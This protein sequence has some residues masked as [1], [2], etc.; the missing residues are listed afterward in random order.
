MIFITTVFIGSY[1]HSGD[2]LPISK[3]DLTEAAHLTYKIIPALYNSCVKRN[4]AKELVIP[5]K[6]NSITCTTQQATPRAVYTQPIPP[7]KVRLYHYIGRNGSLTSVK[8]HG[9]LS[10]HE[11]FRRGLTSFDPSKEYVLRVDRYHTIYFSWF[12]DPVAGSNH[13]AID[14]DPDSTYVHNREIRCHVQKI[15][16]NNY[17]N[18]NASRVLLAD[19]MAKRQI[20]QKMQSDNRTVLFD[21]YT[22]APFHPSFKPGDLH[23]YDS[24]YYFTNEVIFMCPCIPPNKLIFPETESTLSSAE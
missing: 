17:T 3:R 1:I 12:T 7:G 9:L 6:N 13:V 20:A 4:S 24:R 22:A 5:P 16:S 18:Y 23:K 14:V 21:P 19:Y 8:K 10:C 15:G 2:F 11:L